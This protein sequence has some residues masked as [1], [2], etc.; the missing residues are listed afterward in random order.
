MRVA[1]SSLPH[2][3]HSFR[4]WSISLRFKKFKLSKHTHRQYSNNEINGNLHKYYLDDDIVKNAEKT[5]P[6]KNFNA[7]PIYAIFKTSVM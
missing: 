5:R 4:L 6:K 1:S 2:S 7:Y 3:S